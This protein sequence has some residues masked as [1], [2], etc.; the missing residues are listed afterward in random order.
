MG[1]EMSFDDGPNMPARTARL[2]QLW[3]SVPLVFIKQSP[4]ETLRAA[5]TGGWR[6]FYH[7]RLRL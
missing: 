7:F 4:H 5:Q 3:F 2:V 1:Q 6:S